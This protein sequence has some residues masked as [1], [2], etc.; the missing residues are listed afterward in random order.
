MVF[1]G[2]IECRN[3]TAPQTLSFITAAVSSLLMVVTV[4]GNLLICVAVVKDPYK[5]LRTPFNLFLLNISAADLVVGIG[6]LPLSVA[7]HTLEGLGIYN[8]TL[9]KTL[10][11]VFFISCSASVLGIAVLS[12]DRYICVTSPL[13]YRLRL[14]SSRVKKVSLIMWLIS[15]A[16]PFTY[17]Y[18]DFIIYTFVFANGTILFTSLILVF[19]N[20]KVFHSLQ[21]RRKQLQNL[22]ADRENMKAVLI[23]R[24]ERVTKTFLFFLASFLILTMPTLS[25][26]YVLNFSKTSDCQTIHSFRDFQFIFILFPSSVNPFIYALRLPN[27]RNAIKVVMQTGLLTKNLNVPSWYSYSSEALNVQSRRVSSLPEIG[28]LV[29]QLVTSKTNAKTAVKVPESRTCLTDANFFL[30]ANNVGMNNASMDINP[31]S[32]LG[33]QTVKGEEQGISHFYRKTTNL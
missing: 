10:H 2:P 7:Y 16:C 25:F 5:T 27:F 19:V 32:Q 13:K 17:L 26:S 12:L 31:N 30:D 3:A 4:P 24:D 11:L 6:V 15:V 1:G 9:I 22:A 20:H 21:T 14:T 8:V 29:N 28:S 23:Q 18:V 33:A